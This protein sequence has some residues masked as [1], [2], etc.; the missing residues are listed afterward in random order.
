MK[1]AYLY[2]RFSDIRQAEGDSIRRQTDKAHLWCNV[3]G[4][5]LVGEERY[6]DHGI[7]GHKGRHREHGKLS[8]FLNDVA[9]GE[10]PKG[11][12]V[13]AFQPVTSGTRSSRA[14]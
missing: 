8:E 2:A 13:N 7:S 12:V 3:N 11:A 5:T 14:E 9:S 4:Y 6:Q 1:L 10:I